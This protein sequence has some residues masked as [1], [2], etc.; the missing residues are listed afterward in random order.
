MPTHQDGKGKIFTD[1]VRKNPV[2][3]IVKTRTQLIKGIIHLSQEERLVDAINSDR[4]FIPL[5]SVSVFEKI[6]GEEK[7]RTNILILNKEDISWIVPASEQI[8]E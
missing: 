8:K 1:V 4:Q 3:V 2:N 5:T 6:G 7:M